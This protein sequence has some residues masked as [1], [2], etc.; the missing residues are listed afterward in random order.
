[1]DVAN[2]FL[3]QRLYSN[4]LLLKNMVKPSKMNTLSII[5]K[6]RKRILMEKVKN[7]EKSS[8]GDG[9]GDN[10]NDAKTE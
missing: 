9:N 1:M 6:Q 2:D 8:N 7:D 5:L 10:P 4:L 3:I